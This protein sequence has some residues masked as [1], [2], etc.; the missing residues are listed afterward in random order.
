VSGPLE[1][2][3][4]DAGAR[5]AGAVHAG[6]SSVFARHGAAATSQALATQVALDLLKAGG[7]A[8]D[9]AIGANAMLGFAEPFMCGPGGDLFAIVWDP[10]T[11]RLNGLNASGRSPGSL[12]YDAL[13]SRLGAGS[14]A[15][16]FSG[17][18]PI[19]TP[20]A[21]DGWYA[22]HA[23]FGRLPMADVLAPVIAY[24]HEGI[25]VPEII[26]DDW[27][28]SAAALVASRA[29]DG[30][31]DSFRATYLPGG[32]APRKGTLFR[33]PDLA[34]VYERLAAG[35]RDA[36]Y[37]GEVAELIE[38]FVGRAGGALSRTD[39]ATVQCDWVEPVVA[40]YRG[41]TVC[42]LPPNGQGIAALQMLNVLE[43]FDLAALG[44]SSPEFW[45]LL[46]EAKKL[47]FEDR[48]RHYA[49]PD[50]MTMSVDTLVSKQYADERRRLI[51]PN[52]ALESIEPGAGPIGH[53]DTVYLTTADNDGM[54]V[55]LI[56]S[57][58]A[59]FGSGLVPD[60]LGFA[61][62]NRGA[63][64]ALEPGHPNCYA[65]GKR[66]FHTII[67]GFVMQQGEPLTAFGVMGGHMQPQGHAQVLVN[68]IDFGMDLQAAG[69]AARF[70]H[71]GS[72]EPGRRMSD[73]G[74]TIIEPGVSHDVLAG[75]EQRGH[76]V[77]IA[78]AG[79]GGYQ[80]IRRDP[81][82]G[83]YEAATEMRKDG[84]A[85]GY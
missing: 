82:N 49:D 28:A 18:L 64:F 27:R 51:D 79:F 9:A 40:E 48:A 3:G 10:A 19:T 66:P 30:A 43:G 13:V 81:A 21:V 17:P 35:G 67:P 52:R 6:R 1:P 56:Q 59:A 61:L 78:R 37:H 31:L 83:V 84:S 50:F 85:A 33:N 70:R 77:R 39:L 45:H 72:T 58:Y 63:G 38:R 29:L 11:R 16:P 75:L 25:A 73:G 20:G 80:A 15:M 47:A 23:R 24:A 32:D 26:A 4:T 76:R 62:Q 68:M 2:N 65:P 8:A 53:G 57:I 34:R 7:S 55:S 44:R 5:P 22:L 14:R 60:G 54:M 42:E 12:D 69:D 74:S 71:D 41:F 36:F 46:I